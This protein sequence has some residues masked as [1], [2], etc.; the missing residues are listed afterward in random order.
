MN[1]FMA[2]STWSAPMLALRDTISALRSQMAASQTEALTFFIRGVNGDVFPACQFLL[3]CREVHELQ[4]A[5]LG[6]PDG[7]ALRVFVEQAKRSCG[8]ESVSHGDLR[9]RPML[10][11]RGMTVSDT[12]HGMMCASTRKF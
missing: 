8:C 11:G 7:V 2:T 5:R 12:G 1:L 4:P 3:K 9:T 6:H 10:P